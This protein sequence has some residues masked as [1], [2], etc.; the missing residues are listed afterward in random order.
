[1]HNNLSDIWDVKILSEVATKVQEI[2]SPRHASGEFAIL[3]DIMECHF[4]C[5]P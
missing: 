3:I 2:A 1:M 4:K 5:R